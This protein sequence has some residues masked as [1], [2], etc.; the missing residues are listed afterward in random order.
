MRMWMFCIGHV[1]GGGGVAG[2][3]DDVVQD[4]GDERLGWNHSRWIHG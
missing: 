1:K 2:R 3:D 4:G